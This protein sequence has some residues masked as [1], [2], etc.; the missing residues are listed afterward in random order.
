MS[1]RLSQLKISLTVSA[2]LFRVS[3]AVKQLLKISWS[4]IAIPVPVPNSIY[5]FIPFIWQFKLFIPTSVSLCSY[6]FERFLMVIRFSNK[7]VENAKSLLILTH[8]NK[9]KIFKINKK[10]NQINKILYFC[11]QRRRPTGLIIYC[12]CLSFNLK[13]TFLSFRNLTYDFMWNWKAK[14]HIKYYN[15]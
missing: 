4:D 8:K 13:Q 2:S 11:S 12:S 6:N 15:E 9:T 7:I 1:S 14:T 3:F 5:S 10:T